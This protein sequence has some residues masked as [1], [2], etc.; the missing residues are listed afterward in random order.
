MSHSRD[1]TMPDGTAARLHY[2]SDWSGDAEVVWPEPNGTRG[3]L[4]LPGWVVLAIRRDARQELTEALSQALAD[5]AADEDAEAA[6]PPLSAEETAR[7]QSLLEAGSIAEAQRLIFVG[8]KRERAERC[9]E[10]TR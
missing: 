4:V 5:T 6:L 10:A 1:L 3:R 8:L 7:V 2:N 9:G